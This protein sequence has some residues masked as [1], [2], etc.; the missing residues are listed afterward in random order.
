MFQRHLRIKELTIL[1]L[2]A[3]I[4]VPADIPVVQDMAYLNCYFAYIWNYNCRCSHP[5][6]LQ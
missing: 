5:S 2:A 3:D 4:T 1:G 6:H